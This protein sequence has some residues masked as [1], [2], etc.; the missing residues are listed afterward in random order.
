MLTDEEKQ[1]ARRFIKAIFIEIEKIAEK[2][3]SE[4]LESK[5]GQALLEKCYEE[6]DRETKEKADKR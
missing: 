1:T 3:L 2:T 4:Y 6:A 5:E